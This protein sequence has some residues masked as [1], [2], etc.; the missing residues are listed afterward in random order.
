M[1][2]IGDRVIVKGTHFL[3]GRKGTVVLLPNDQGDYSYI[4]YGFGIEF[5][6]PHSLLHNCRGKTKK[7]HGTWVM[8]ENLELLKSEKKVKEKTMFKIGDRVRVIKFFCCAANVGDEGIIRALPGDSG[9]KVT[10][11]HCYAV[12]FPLSKIGHDCNGK[13]PSR[14]GFWLPP[15]CLELIKPKPKSEKIVITHDGKT[16]LARLYEGKTVVKSAEAKCHPRDEFKFTEGAKI[17][18]ERLTKE[19]PPFKVGDVVKVKAAEYH[20]FID[21]TIGRVIEVYEDGLEVKSYSPD[22]DSVI[23]QR[24]D[25]EDCEKVKGNA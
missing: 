21:G 1:F 9:S 2:K 8:P 12:E 11:P 14:R 13:V 17:A 5:D 7:D 15:E 24:I 25:F 20:Y 6:E 16:T 3:S 23:K 19:E 22:K 18:F 10:F 4:G